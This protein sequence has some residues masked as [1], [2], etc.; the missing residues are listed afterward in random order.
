VVR[1]QELHD[2]LK[3]DITI[4]ALVSK[5]LANATS[6]RSTSSAASIT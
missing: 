4:R 5:R 2:L 3:E 1:R 6:A